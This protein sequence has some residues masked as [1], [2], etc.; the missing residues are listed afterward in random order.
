VLAFDSIQSMT[1]AYKD[2]S[3]V[4][5]LVLFVGH[6]MNC[7]QKNEM[8]ASQLTMNENEL[9]ITSKVITMKEVIEDME[10]TMAAI[11]NLNK[12]SF[13]PY[14]RPRPVPLIPPV[15]FRNSI[16]NSIRLPVKTFKIPL[17]TLKFDINY[18]RQAKLIQKQSILVGKNDYGSVALKDTF[19]TAEVGV[20]LSI[21][22]DF[23]G[24]KKYSLDF[25]GTV[26]ASFNL[27]T[28]SYASGNP[29]FET[30]LRTWQPKPLNSRSLSKMISMSRQIVKLL[31]KAMET[32]SRS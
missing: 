25:E 18:D 3:A 31:V 10:L 7:L 19:A 2:W 32:I 11:S 1:K 22:A 24:I 30:V 8:V 28:E 12:R 14:P 5:N 20:Y 9:M 23:L 13:A 6:E 16:H 15:N 4:K 27:D 17:R 21:T 26:D 29:N